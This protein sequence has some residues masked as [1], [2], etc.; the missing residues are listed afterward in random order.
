MLTY[1]TVT[2]SIDLKKSC[3]LGWG[4]FRRIMDGLHNFLFLNESVS[5][6][7][8]VV[9][10]CSI[11]FLC[12]WFLSMDNLFHEQTY[13]ICYNTGISISDLFYIYLRD[14]SN[15]VHKFSLFGSLSFITCSTKYSMGICKNNRAVS[16]VI[17]QSKGK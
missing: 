5:V 15:V 17:N 1:A 6:S 3:S 12:H 8:R 10:R 7:P 16:F 4:C 9:D 11:F 2:K 13:M 14:L